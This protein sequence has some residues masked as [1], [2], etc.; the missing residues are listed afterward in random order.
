MSHYHTVRQGEH[1]S[2]IAKMHGF[3]DYKLLWDRGENSGLQ[4]KRQNPNVLFQGDQVFIPDK[5]IKDCACSTDKQH[6]FEVLR[7][8]LQLRLKL[9]N[10]YYKPL[11]NT[12][13]QLVVL[14]DVFNLNSDDSGSIEH[15]IPKTAQNATLFIKQVVQTR[16]RE[17][18]I[19]LEVAVRIGHL[20]PVEEKSGQAARLANLGYYRGDMDPIDEDELL[21]SI[22]EFQCENGVTVDGKCGPVTQAKLKA[23]HGC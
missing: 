15:E 13:C 12:A 1:L 18:P 5:I 8:P 23:I 9:E 4:Q 11:A 16:A 19:R 3:D 6:E 10:A 22:E 7:K 21:S 17:I 20:D 2:S 14:T